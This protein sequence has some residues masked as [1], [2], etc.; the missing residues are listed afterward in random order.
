MTLV[1]EVRPNR[2][3][4]SKQFLSTSKTYCPSPKSTD[5]L[6]LFLWQCVPVQPTFLSPQLLRVTRN[7]AQSTSWYLQDTRNITAIGGE[8]VPKWQSHMASWLITGQQ[9]AVLASITALSSGVDSCLADSIL[10]LL[11]L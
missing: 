4:C 11:K 8:M 6:N 3:C 10:V 1:G 2:Q 9:V 7:A 5:G